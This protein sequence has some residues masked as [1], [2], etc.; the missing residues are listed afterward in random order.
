MSAIAGIYQ[1]TNEPVAIDNCKRMMS[2]LQCYPADQVDVWV[3]NHIFLGCHAQWI[4]PESRGERL[5]YYDCS[6]KL[7]ITA[8]AII[9]N[10]QELFDR[11]GV[12]YEHRKLMSDSELILLAYEKWGEELPAY[13]IG[14]FAFMIWNE[15]TQ[16]LFGA[17]DFSGGRTLYFH[18]D[19]KRFSFCTVIEP[20]FSLPYIE[21]KLNEQW[22]AEF[23]AIVGMVDVADSFITPYLGIQ[24]VP[25]SHSIKVKNGKVSFSRYCTLERNTSIKFKSNEEYIEAFRDI[26]QEAVNSRMRTYKEVSAQ[27]SGGLDSGSIVG[28][29]ARGLRAQNKQL[30]TLSYIPTSDFPD[31]TPYYLMPNEQEYM[32]ETVQFVGNINDQY[33]D[34]KGRNSYTE[35][36]AFLTAMEMPYKFFENSFWMK[37]MFEQAS[38]HGAGV[39]LNGGRG[40][41]SISWGSATD[42][43]ALL[44]KRLKWVRLYRELDQYS[45][46]T[47]GMRLRRIPYIARQAFPFLERH[48]AVEAAPPVLI[49]PQFAHRT[50]VYEKLQGYGMNSS[51]WFSMSDPFEQRNSHFKELFHWN[52]S[53]TIST[54]LSLQYGVWKRDPSND[55]RVIRFCLSIPEEQYVQDG[56]DR[57]LIR[58]AT[59]DILPDKVRLNQ[60]IYGVQG[61]DW[62]YRMTPHWERFMDEV[63]EMKKDIDLLVFVNPEALRLGLDIAKQGPKAEHAIDFNHKNLMRSVIIYRFLKQ[64]S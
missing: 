45:K 53:N 52:A 24:Q 36:D 25:P 9:D 27:L 43:Y 47:G 56:L 22:L 31:F 46:R 42:Y 14:D 8:D 34:F 4:T 3:Q 33:L 55:L 7:A 12:S 51:G 5:P 40:N 64:F 59:E 29:A 54:K 35:I 21:K 48:N 49:H 13:L 2:S 44:L 16:E 60:H 38:I 26:F 11:I 58:R 23:L 10:R 20:L 37:G 1:T 18:H 17:R 32:K 50:H 61:A 39:L 28:F 19:E 6:R 41:L 15:Q 63:R 62:V 30:H 57:A